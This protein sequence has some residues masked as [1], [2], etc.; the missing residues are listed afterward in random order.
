MPINFFCDCS[1]G[2]RI[3]P[4]RWR[5][6]SWSNGFYTRRIQLQQQKS[7][8]SESDDFDDNELK[9]SKDSVVSKGISDYVDERSLAVIDEN[10]TFSPDPPNTVSIFLLALL[11][12]SGIVGFVSLPA[13]VAATILFALFR[14]IARQLI[15]LDET[16][17]Y[18]TTSAD[19]SLDNDDDQR[20]IPLQWQIDGVSF[21]LSFFTAELL[22][23]STWIDSWNNHQGDIGIAAPVVFVAVVL[24]G[25]WFN[26]VIVHPLVQDEQL[27][28]Q[29][30]L[31]NQW[32]RNFFRQFR[33]HDED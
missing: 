11:G 23:P 19:G 30:R 32:D 27:S 8:F 16:V 12:V 21:V 5:S 31:L 28:E 20:A 6:Y 1:N 2:C 24:S 7:K 22:V 15:I 14:I 9:S 13:A 29:D 17:E 3:S 18:P 10:K 26:T 25:L 4:T 33:S